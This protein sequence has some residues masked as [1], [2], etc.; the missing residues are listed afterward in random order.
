MS[1]HTKEGGMKNGDITPEGYTI[2]FISEYFWNLI[3]KDMVKIMRSHTNDKI[4]NF[5]SL[6][7]EPAMIEFH[8]FESNL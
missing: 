1:L 8:K 4:Y 5:F 7:D 2:V 6:R 3:E